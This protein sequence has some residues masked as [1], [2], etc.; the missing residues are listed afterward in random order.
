MACR[1]RFE[2]TRNPGPEFRIQFGQ[3]DLAKPEYAKDAVQDAFMRIF[4][5]FD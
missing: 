5:A 3:L 2:E 4:R 1:S